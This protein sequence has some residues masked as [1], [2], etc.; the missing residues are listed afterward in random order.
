MEAVLNEI[1]NIEGGRPK[2]KERQ[3]SS[4][5]QSIESRFADMMFQSFF[6]VPYSHRR[7]RRWCD[8]CQEY[9]S[10]SDDDDDDDY[11]Y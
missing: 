11:D 7:G 10:Y 1:Y 6:G 3:R 4:G 9:H 8:E 5:T 2:P